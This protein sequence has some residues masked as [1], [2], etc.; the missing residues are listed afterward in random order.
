MIK[1]YSIIMMMLLFGLAAFGQGGYSLEGIVVDSASAPLEWASILLFNPQD[2]S[3]IA[4]AYSDAKGKFKVNNLKERDYIL[5][6]GFL[7]LTSYEDTLYIN[8][9]RN[10]GLIKLVP[11]SAELGEVQVTATRIPIL[12]KK[13]TTEYDAA[14]FR[15]RPNASVEELLKQLPGVEVEQDGT[16][17][18]QGEEVKNVLVD[19]RRFFGNDPKLATKNLPADAVEKVQVYDR[20]SETS[21]FTGIDDGERE[22]TIN[23]LLK[24]DR[25]KG[26]FGYAS[27][28]YGGPDNR[29]DGKLSL[30]RFSDSRQVAIL[31]SGNN[32]NQQ[33]FSF[34][35]YM[36]FSGGMANFGRG[37]GG[38]GRGNAPIN[39]GRDNGFTTALNTGIQFTERWGKE[40]E[41]N[42]SYFYNQVTNLTESD[43]ERL[44]F[45]PSGGQ[46]I[47]LENADRRSTNYNHR[48]NVNYD[49]K[50]DTFSAI[51]LISNLSVTTGLNDNMQ[52]LFNQGQEGRTVDNQSEQ[53]LNNR[54]NNYS[55]N[56]SLTWRRRFEKRG[57]V[58]ATTAGGNVRSNIQDAQLLAV[59]RFIDGGTT[60]SEEIIDQQQD[61]DNRNWSIRGDIQF[62]EPLG[63]R[64]FLEMKYQVSH[65]P[66]RNTRL[67]YDIFGNEIEILNPDLSN[68][69]NAT[70]GFQRPGISYR[71]ITD[72]GNFNV[73]VDGKFSTLSGSIAG[74]ENPVARNF[75]FLLPN[76]RWT[77]TPV[78]TTNINVDYNTSVREPAVT[79]LQPVVDNTDP[80]NIYIGNEDLKPEFSHR[81]NARY[82]KFNPT[83]FQ[84][85]FLFAN[86]TYTQ[87]RIRETQTIDEELRRVRTP[88]NVRGEWDFRSRI[89][90]GYPI[91]KLGLR[92]NVSGGFNYN[93]GLTFVNEVENQ[94]N[95]VTPSGNVRVQY[96]LKSYLDINVG[97]GVDY[98]TTTYSVQRSLDQTFYTYN[99]NA[100]IR[101]NWPEKWQFETGINLAQYRGQA[102]V[103]NEDI[104]IWTASISRFFLQKDRGELKIIAYDLL[105]QNRGISRLADLNY[106]EDQRILSLGR[107]ILVEFRYN[108]NSSPSNQQ[109]GMGRMFRFMM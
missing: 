109:G 67:V 93:W 55:W 77:Y 49:Q 7:G 50:I 106:I 46:F 99:H 20:K 57:R 15:V 59:N 102:G 25:K 40:N 36:Q 52:N 89:N 103:F 90:W 16:I 27:G 19:G 4:F 29:Y 42:A 64:Q 96:Q 56:G 1:R 24:P 70:F 73:G 21:E 80:L 85:F 5:K 75:N 38:G 81:L 31:A 91:Q 88:I 43:L 104:P 60:I 3:M 76:F 48:L 66:M 22:K 26:A 8:S 39:Q 78:R 53:M 6:I 51:K 17:K 63:N 32:I 107:Y 87:D 11:Y 58:L 68:G 72:K 2:S 83:N 82:S 54:G 95:R 69:F 97:T 28:A 34:Q 84:N 79:Q 105:N 35:D 18:A 61:T 101:A 74:I 47:T 71:K 12:I 14:S 9:D 94:T 41:L 65:A 92:F 86:V 98:T 108:I 13:D 100:S 37:G 10:L 33:G 44:T 45:L 30:N 23:L 62:T